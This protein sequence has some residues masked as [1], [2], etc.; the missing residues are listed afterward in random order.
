MKIASFK[1]KARMITYYWLIKILQLNFSHAN[2]TR[3]HEGQGS[4]QVPRSSNYKHRISFHLLDFHSQGRFLG[5]DC[6]QKRFRAATT[7]PSIG[8]VIKLVHAS[9]LSVL[10]GKLRIVILIRKLDNS[11]K[12]TS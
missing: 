12:L 1:L 5:P 3:L 9:G 10:M 4:S 2:H 11:S 7:R 8:E 6:V